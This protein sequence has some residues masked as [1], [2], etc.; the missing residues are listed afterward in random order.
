MLRHR[1]DAVAA[2]RRYFEIEVGL[3]F[4][5]RGEVWLDDGSDGAALW[6]R[7]GAW[8]SAAHA[9]LNAIVGYLRIFTRR[10]MTASRVAET[11]ARA[12]P[13]EPH[14]YLLFVGVVAEAGGSG[15]GAE[16]LRPALARCDEDGVP[17]YLEATS[18]ASARLFG[19]LA[20][21][22]L[23]ELVLPTDVV[24]RRMWREPRTGPSSAAPLQ[25]EA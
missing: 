17:A 22:P 5:G 4:G 7:P 9:P 6:H 21:Q 18:E 24:V 1:P 3:A 14:W 25:S 20:C 19:R 15:K 12:H 23:E 13:H 11:L 8:P 10:F 16:L 2:L